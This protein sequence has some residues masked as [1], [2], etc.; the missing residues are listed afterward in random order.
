MAL[1]DVLDFEPWFDTGFIAEPRYLPPWIASMQ[2]LAGSLAFSLFINR[3]PM[4][5]VSAANWRAR[6][7]A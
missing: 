6:T 3:I 1:S 7:D 4:D 2:G 5:E